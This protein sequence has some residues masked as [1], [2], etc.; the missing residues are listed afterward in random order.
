MRVSVTLTAV[1][2]AITSTLAGVQLASS[3][4]ARADETTVSQ[5]LSRDGWDSH[6]PMLSPASVSSPDFG[7]LFRTRVNGQVFAQPLTIGGSVLVATEDD[8]VYSINRDTGAVNWSRQL[9]SPWA[10]ATE[11]CAQTPVV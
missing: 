8:Y 10:A 5:N 6:E 9:G 11:N 4:P 3:G 1:A 7:Q 2:L